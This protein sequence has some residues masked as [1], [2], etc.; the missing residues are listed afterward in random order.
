[1][2]ILL[3]FALLAGACKKDMHEY[4][5]NQQDL[6]PPNAGKTKLKTNEQYVSILYANLFQT[7]LSSNR[8]FQIT[9]CIESVGDKELVREVIISNFMNEQ[10]VIIPS[11]SIMR[12]DVDLFLSETYERF[13]VREMSEAE[14]TW[15]RN[16]I[17]NNPN[18]TPELIYF[19]FALSNEYLFY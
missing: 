15:F 14:R 13:Y 11:D 17:E 3:G 10:E 6:Q 2:T 16:Y 7:A 12:A 19:S 5:V 8:L 4:E 18:V 1:M 9:Q